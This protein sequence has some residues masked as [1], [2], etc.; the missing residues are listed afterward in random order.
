MVQNQ[1]SKIKTHKNMLVMHENPRLFTNDDIQT[2]I[3]QNQIK[4]KSKTSIQDNNF[5]MNTKNMNPSCPEN[6]TY[7]IKPRKYILHL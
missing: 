2:C 3:N 6:P 5:Q 7:I 4:I 1:N